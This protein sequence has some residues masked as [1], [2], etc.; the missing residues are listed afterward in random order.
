M[1]SS[2]FY[3]TFFHKFYLTTIYLFEQIKWLNAQFHFTQ[4]SFISILYENNS[5]LHMFRLSARMQPTPGSRA[6]KQMMQV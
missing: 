5:L 6:N 4:V 1:L 2:W 3:N